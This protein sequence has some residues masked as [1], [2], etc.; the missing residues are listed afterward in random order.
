M[1]AL[2]RVKQLVGFTDRECLAETF[3]EELNFQSRQLMPLLHCMSF[4][5]LLYIS[6]DRALHPELPVIITLRWLLLG[7]GAFAF[8][9]S[10][11]P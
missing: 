8:V 3:S 2:D 1:K 5:W 9:L 4:A 6:I 10:R 7:I 11:F